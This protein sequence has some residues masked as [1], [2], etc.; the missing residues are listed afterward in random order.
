M[1]CRIE[2]KIASSSLKN[3][4]KRA[5]SQIFQNETYIEFENILTTYARKTTYKSKNLFVSKVKKNKSRSHSSQEYFF[6]I[7]DH[8]F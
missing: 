8:S 6:Y 1:H 5:P 2:S 7:R 3:V 4:F